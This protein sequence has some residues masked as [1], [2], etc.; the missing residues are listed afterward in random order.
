M[1][2]FRMSGSVVL[3]LG[4]SLRMTDLEVLKRQEGH[5]VN[6]LAPRGDEGRGTLR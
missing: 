1:C 6:A 3:C 5:L 4:L 2:K